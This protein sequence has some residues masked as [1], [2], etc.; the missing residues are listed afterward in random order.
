MDWRSFTY[1]ADNTSGIADGANVA[2]TSE[3]RTD[4][5]MTLLIPGIKHK[6]FKN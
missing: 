5:M 6:D 3:A 2:P 1:F 4:A